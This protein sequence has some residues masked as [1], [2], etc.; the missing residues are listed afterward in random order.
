MLTIQKPLWTSASFSVHFLSAQTGRISRAY[1]DGKGGHKNKYEYIG[2]RWRKIENK[3][4]KCL[5]LVKY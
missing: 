4:N 1:N 5:N 3:S 2:E